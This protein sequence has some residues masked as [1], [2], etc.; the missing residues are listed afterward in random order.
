VAQ[1]VLFGLRPETQLVDMVDDLAKVV[2][3][4]NRMA[5]FR[6]SA[7]RKYSF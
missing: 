5:R 1:F 3:A 6:V 4:L 7:D 2:A